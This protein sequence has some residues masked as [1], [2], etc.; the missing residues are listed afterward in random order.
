MSRTVVTTAVIAALYTVFTLALAPI[1]YGPVQFRAAELLKPLALYNPI[2]ALGFGLGNFFAN[3][4]SPFGAWD[5]VVMPLVDIGAA[6]LCWQLR[7]WPV[8]AVTI[9]AIVISAGVA[10]FPL[11]LGGR[12]P[13]L[14]S[15]LA[16]LLSE[17]IILVLG[18]LVIWRRYDRV[19]LLRR[20]Q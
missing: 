3:L 10:I 7:R 14:P 11:G 2:F 19:D 6:L 12:F 1:S 13:V 20:W 17:L 4:G 16:V 15:F 5:F 8:P 9:Q 18:Y